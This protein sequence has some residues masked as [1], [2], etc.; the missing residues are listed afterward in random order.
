MQYFPSLKLILTCVS[1]CCSNHPEWIRYRKPYRKFSISEPS[2]GSPGVQAGTCSQELMQRSWRDV[3]Y[4]LASHGLLCMLSYRTQGLYSRYLFPFQSSLEFSV[5]VWTQNITRVHSGSC[6][7]PGRHCLRF[8]SNP[9]H[10]PIITSF[11]SGA[12]SHFSPTLFIIDHTSSHLPWRFVY[13][14]PREW[15]Y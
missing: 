1:G 5:S 13:A 4:W 3:P 10:R 2:I 14:Q 12:W 7:Y 9:H 6:L 15:H 8:R 11:T